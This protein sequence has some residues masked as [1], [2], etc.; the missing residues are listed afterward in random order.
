M[1]IVLVLSWNLFHGRSLPA[2]DRSLYDEFAAKLGEWSWDVALLQEVPPWWPAP[3]AREL[4][5]EQRMALTSRNAP[6]ALRRALAERRPELLK[7]NGGGCNAILSRSPIAV[8]STLR[9]RRWPERR[10]AHLA[11]L[12]NGTCVVNVHASTR[13][14]RAVQELERLWPRALD[15]ART[16]PLILGGDLNLRTPPLPRPPAFPGASRPG[17][18]VASEHGGTIVHV[19]RSGVDHVYAKGLLPTEQDEAAAG[20]PARPSRE[21]VLDGRRVELSDHEPLLAR[22]RTQAG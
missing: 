3:L 9:L 8:H 1:T 11:R 10:V 7:S 5:V 21:V 14:A 13:P 16:G 15:W 6:L 18:G 17:S 12:R 20:A 2:T 22:L 4:G 19:A